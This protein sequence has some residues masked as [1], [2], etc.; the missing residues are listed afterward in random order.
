MGR[1]VGVPDRDTGRGKIR[2]AAEVEATHT[3][4]EERATLCKRKLTSFEDF[5][6]GGFYLFGFPFFFLFF[7]FRKMVLISV[8]EFF[9][10]VLT[11]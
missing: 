9:L 3:V 4:R 8:G 1:G 6:A 11:S 5:S 2:L 10:L 7:L